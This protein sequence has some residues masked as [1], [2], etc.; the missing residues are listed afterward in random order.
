MAC[1]VAPVDQSQDAPALAVSVTEP[2]S[3][4]AVGPE[5]VIVAVGRAFTVTV[6]AD[7][8]ALQPSAFV[9]VTE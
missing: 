5:G 8:V 7:D 9:T 2:P 3:Q 4:N 1:V 6:V